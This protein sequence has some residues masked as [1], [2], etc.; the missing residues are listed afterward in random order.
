M[1][2]ALALRDDLTLCAGFVWDVSEKGIGRME[3]RARAR[4][5]RANAHLLR[6]GEKNLGV[7]SLPLATDGSKRLVSVA[8]TL[9]SCVDHDS[10]CG[11]FNIFNSFVFVGVS[12]GNVLAD[13]DT[14]YE[15][16]AQ[17]EDRLLSE[18]DLFSKAFAPA[19]WNLAAATPSEPL[20]DAV[21][22]SR[23][24][25]VQ[26]NSARAKSPR[27]ALLVVG[28]LG[29][30]GFAGWAYL[31]KQAG[32]EASQSVPQLALPASTS[33]TALPPPILAMS[34]CLQIREELYA[35]SQDGWILSS[36]TCDVQ[37][38][39]F[40]ATL[41]PY[42]E[43][44]RLPT[45]GEGVLIEMKGNG[46][47]LGVSGGLTSESPA[48]RAREKG[49]LADALQA[50]NYIFGF[51]SQMAWQTEKGMH[52]FNF[53][54][55]ANFDAVAARLTTVPTLSFTKIEMIG[56]DWR[57]YGEVWQ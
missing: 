42:T 15:A 30:V 16:R 8:A 29:A 52:Q 2:V 7:G 11:V 44:N 46:N 38:K 40:S 48:D 20:F 18:I 37:S 23:A 31:D 10:W 22:W 39:K 3:A 35:S 24:E 51:S 14:V 4:Q 56:D 53:K 57:V 26:F 45:V 25:T 34:E 1:A 27:V 33:W 47:G 50:R 36:L 5:A 28:L 19:G 32:D 54:M 43:A 6:T 13:G 17:A 41:T 55:P 21:D 9:A 12:G 49:S